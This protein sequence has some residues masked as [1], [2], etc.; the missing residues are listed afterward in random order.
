MVDAKLRKERKEY[1]R[2]SLTEVEAPMNPMDMFQAWFAEWGQ[3]GRVDATAFTLATA[4]SDGVPDARI[5]LLKG[6]ENGK[7]VFFTNYNSSKGRQ[8]A[9]N[10]QATLLFFWSDHER[11]VRVYGEVEKLSAEE[12]R[13]YFKER[14]VGSQIGAI[15]SPQS[16]VISGREYLDEQVK[17]NTELYGE[18]GPDCPDFWGGYAVKPTK[19]E[20]WQGR[21]SRLHDRLQYTLMKDTWKLERLAP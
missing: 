1:V 3:T 12:N 19:I 10:P 9:E 21:A 20:F 11:Q 16:Q 4:S 5:V 8:L 18:E 7:F 17:V 2:G 15:S 6:I 13:S 14:P